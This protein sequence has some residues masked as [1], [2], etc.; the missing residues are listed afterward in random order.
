MQQA[1]FRIR[2]GSSHH[3]LQKMGNVIVKEVVIFIIY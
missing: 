2:R 1:R 3:E